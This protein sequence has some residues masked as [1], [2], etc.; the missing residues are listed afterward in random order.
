MENE[1][2]AFKASQPTLDDFQ[3]KF[4]ELQKHDERI[5]GEPDHY[6]VGALYIGLEDFKRKIRAILNTLKKVHSS[7][8]YNFSNIWINS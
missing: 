7:Y 5:E 8:T 2:E 6:I 3:H 4:I 1:L